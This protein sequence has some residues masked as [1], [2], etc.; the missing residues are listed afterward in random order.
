[1]E[2]DTSDTNQPL[3]TSPDIASL[4]EDPRLIHN[5]QLVQRPNQGCANLGKRRTNESDRIPWAKDETKPKT[6]PFGVVKLIFVFSVLYIG[7]FGQKVQISL[8]NIQKYS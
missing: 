4:M 1:M 5:M 2:D 8:K 6:R 3:N 7:K